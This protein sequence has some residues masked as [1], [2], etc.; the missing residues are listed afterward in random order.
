MDED[1]F[2]SDEQN[3]KSFKLMAVGAVILAAVLIF[4]GI[5]ISKSAQ[6]DTDDAI[7]SVSRLYLKDLSGHCKKLVESRLKLITVH[8]NNALE[9]IDE[10]DLQSQAALQNW[11]GQIKFISDVN[12]IILV[13]ATGKAYT[14]QETFSNFEPDSS[15]VE[16]EMKAKPFMD[17]Q[18]VRAFVRVNF[19]NVLDKDHMHESGEST[20]C[21]LYNRNG[22]PL[23]HTNNQRFSNTA[24]L[25]DEI[26]NFKFN[27][28]YNLETARADFQAGNIG[29]I[30][31][32]IEENHDELLIYTP[33]EN[34]DWM[35]ICLIREDSI[36]E[37]IDAVS[38]GIM[39]RSMIQ[40]MLTIL[41]MAIICGFILKQAKRTAQIIHEKEISETT[42]QVK[43]AEMEEKI[44]LQNKL[45]EQERRRNHQ[46]EMI[47]ALSSDYRTVYYYDL[48]TDEGTCY[49]STA[50]VSSYNE[51]DTI[52]SF[53]NFVARYI[54]NNVTA[55]DRADAYK[56]I[57]PQNLRERLKT[58][59]IIS[60]RFLAARDGQEYYAMIRVARIDDSEEIH[61]VG[62]GFVNVDEQT[63]E[64]MAQN[65][66]L[67][68]ALNQAQQANI[69]KT[70]FLSNMSHDIR[71][72]MN[73]IIGFT[74]MALRNFENQVQVKDSLEKVLT[75][76]K[77]LLGLINDILDM[78]RIESGRVEVQ[79]EDC[80][81]SELVHS[82]IHI[83]QPQI[84]AKQ[85]SFQIDAVKI[86]NEDVL[87]DKLK[88][89]QILINLLSNAIKYTQSTGTI[90]FTISQYK[91]DK[92]GFATYEFRVKDNGMGMSEEFLKHIFDPF[93]REATSTKSGIQG[94]GLGM[95]ITKKMVEL[96]G[97]TISV[98]SKKGEGS[99]FIVKLDLKIVEEA[100]PIP[101]SNLEGMHALIVDDDFH[102]CDSLT[103]M[104]NKIGM[105]SEWTTSPREA[106]FRT[107]KAINDSDPFGVYV[108]DWLMPELNGVETVRQIRKIAGESAAIIILTAYDYT[109]IID[110]AKAAGVTG[111][112]TKPLFPSDLKKALSRVTGHVE[113]EKADE[114]SET[115]FQGKRVL[116]VEDIEVNREIAKMV[117]SEMELD[118]DEATDGTEAVE[119]FKKSSPNYY[120][121]ILMDIQMP[122]MNGYEATKV[123]RKL[124]R[125]DSK[126]VPI[127]AMTA[128]AF[129][130]DKNNVLE[131][132]MND[133][134]AKPL[135]I[136][137]LL[138]TLKKYLD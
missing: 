45:L 62:I 100:N 99:E 54:E 67:A 76:G 44:S 81:L 35:L 114:L 28:G 132:G 116:L 46:N 26:K 124:T 60:H 102:T 107:R 42:N 126:T 83:I 137:K 120:D 59:N 115:S 113:E 29:L 109:D 51:G 57:S 32:A 111:F 78:S 24:N 136:P 11:I 131:A 90:N 22:E 133:H 68:Y 50:G 53:S 108:V 112:C 119:M 72:P 97:G 65:Q 23:T 94:T 17:T 125:A 74:T 10:A 12:E 31:F 127:I 71:T 39:D 37:Q 110:E 79:V 55:G 75:S 80:N 96:M 135:D 13:D 128:N 91:S 43:R 134:I 103:E 41:V 18:I 101:L 118:I 19:E 98:T 34:T 47:R 38:N 117:L 92:A 40:M 85:Q 87:A 66:A 77:H 7:H 86:Q 56:F 48:D 52:Q 138:M 3:Q 122:V 61:A 123:I 82:L 64:T 25:F 129:D 2:W 49:R 70:T 30:S 36:G 93:E 6:R 20:V 106:I 33:I 21:N 104:L 88:I 73:A 84:T 9:I 15:V 58:E 69:S 4:T 8:I 105:R 130:E 95:T 121:A 16:V 1:N 27:A 63:R 5:W 14:A 89:N